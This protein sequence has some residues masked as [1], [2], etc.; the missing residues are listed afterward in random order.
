M[1]LYSGQNK[2]TRFYTTSEIGQDDGQSEV[3]VTRL[4]E[5]VVC[6]VCGVEYTDQD[7]VD[8]VKGWLAKDNYAPCPNLSCRGQLEVKGV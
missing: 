4:T 5:K 8:T 6:N 7:S 3:E 1:V 2:E